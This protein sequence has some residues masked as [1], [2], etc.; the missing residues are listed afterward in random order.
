MGKSA[1]IEGDLVTVGGTFRRAEG[2][3][4]EGTIQ[5]EPAINIPV[6]VAPEAP[7][8]PETPRVTMNPV[9]SALGVLGRS[10]GLAALAMLLS[11]FLR[12]QMERVAQTA[13]S[14]PLVAG[15]VGLLTVVLFPLALVIL[16]IT[17]IL[18]PLLV[19]VLVLAWLFGLVALG[20]EVGVL[21]TRSLDQ[22]W[23]PVFTAGF[24]TFFLMLVFGSFDMLDLVP[25]MSC[26]SWI[27]SFLLGVLGVGAVALTFV[28]PMLRRPAAAVAPPAPGPDEALPPAS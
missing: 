11:L 24:G 28:G 2:S 22:S 13:V 12:P 16:L 17:L 26:I 15:G 8:V 23:P 19:I 18:P 1:V 10:I 3:R 14:Q 4:I 7:S 6:P 25:G 20:W 27:P 9:G 21:F 5:E